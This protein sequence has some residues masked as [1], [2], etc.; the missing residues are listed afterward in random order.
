[1]VSEQ[2]TRACK[3]FKVIATICGSR[4]F[5]AAKLGPCQSDAQI[6]LNLKLTFDGDDELRDNGENFGSAL[7]EHVES[8]LDREESVWFLLLADSFEED[9]EVVVVVEGHD[10]DFPEEFVLRAVVDG[11]G[12][13]ASVVEATELGCWNWTSIS[14]SCF[15]FIC[16][17]D[18]FW[19]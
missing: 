4:V 15:W 19:S 6:N 14:G 5:K 3:I 17:G 7:F 18:W 11:D 2:V 13:V 16:T 1:M 10:V 8:S 9:W 12:E